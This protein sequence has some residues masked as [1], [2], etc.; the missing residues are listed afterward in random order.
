MV[1]LTRVDPNDP[2]SER[3]FSD[4]H[5]GV[6]MQKAHIV[7]G[8]D[9]T[10]VGIILYS[11]KTHVLQGM[12]CYPLYSKLLCV[13]FLYSCC[14]LVVILVALIFDWH[15]CVQ[16]TVTL[17]NLDNGVRFTNDAWQ[18][19]A[20]LPI[21]SKTAGNY[22]GKMEISTRKNQL[23]HGIPTLSQCFFC[24]FVVWCIFDI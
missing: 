4:M 5:T 17:V 2:E 23:F 12:S 19:V 7:A 3:V 22:K 18:L 21:P 1:H 10:P 13:F 6:W 20:L 8:E 15:L 24:E 16:I 11:D 14:I 9:K